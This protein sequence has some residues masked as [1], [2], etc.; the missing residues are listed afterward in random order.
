M[1][2]TP[3]TTYNRLQFRL[4]GDWQ[5]HPVALNDTYPF[6]EKGDWLTIPDSTHL[7]PV[8]YPDRPYWGDH[9]RALNEQAWIYRRTF[10]V[11]H[12]PYKRARLRF[13]GVDY[14]ASVWVNG[15]F[16][17]EH[18]G[19]FAPFSLDVTDFVRPESEN[20]LLVRVSSPWDA[21]NPKGTYP[22]DHVI[23]GLVKGHYEHG[24]GVIPPDVNPIGIWRPVWLLLDEGLNLDQFRIRTHLDG[25]IDL[26]VTCTNATAESW[27]GTLDLQVTAENH[28]GDGASANYRLTIAPGTHELDYS[29]QVADPHLWWP[30]DHGD[31][32]LYRLEASLHDSSG[33]T[34]SNRDE[35]FGLRTVRLERSQQRFTY[36]INER[37]VFIRGTSYMPTLYL[38][39]CTREALERD[40]G[41][42]RKANLNLVRV[43]VHVSPPEL[44]ELCDH[45]G[46]L[47]WQDFELNWVQDYSADF[48]RR[49]RLLQREMIAM[50]GNH[51]AI[52][53]WACHNEPTMI[54]TRRHN[55]ERRPDPA[56]YA[57]AQQQDPTRPV[58][59]CSG[60]MERD[61]Q[62]SGDV[63]SYYGALWTARY[64]E[65]Y[66]HAFLLNSE[67]GFEVP[68]ALATLQ[69][70][71]DVWERLR[72]LEGQIDDLW[73]Y[74]AELIQ[75]QVEHLRRLRATCSAGYV[76]FWL[77]DL[78]PQVGCGV[79]DARRQPKGG[80]EALRCA[81]GPLHV[82]LEHD[83][84]RPFALW[85]FNDTPQAYPDVL[86]RW[87]IRDTADKILVEGEMKYAIAANASQRIITTDWA[88]SPAQCARV[89]LALYTGA[90]DLLAE[91]HYRHPFQPTLRPRGYPWKFDRYLGTKIFD[92]P[93]ASSL[94]D[95][96]INWI[97]HL[98]PLMLRERIA[99]WALRQ[100]FPHWFTSGLARIIDRLTG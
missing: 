35:V 69:Q 65:I 80:Y 61:W 89:E 22:A 76:H 10:S 16:A 39:Q 90:G 70:Y 93:G 43:H 17:G 3:S 94:A 8:L 42:V 100:H 31:P 50:L 85:V 7:Q 60:Q 82:A 97:F 95:Y 59:I 12:V 11:P 41:F 5:V 74:Q 56:L 77:A 99:E 40:I 67:F 21:P 20:T 81:S 37:A 52:I 15:H 72:H 83:G 54:F 9:L 64:T 91:N 4:T 28:N 49:A 6:R 48:E 32:N 55:L 44:Y 68:A 34:V 45:A 66:P 98:A 75:Y 23:R 63:H 14:Y 92:R 1:T 25:R 30:W 27:E 26:Q 24:E 19:S 47:I 36:W 33:H 71:P 58:F 2:V 79:L 78:V 73:A 62:R 13:E 38:S 88:I 96:N 46:I 18:E 51:P 86:L 53:T 84:R 87:R 29:L 57:D